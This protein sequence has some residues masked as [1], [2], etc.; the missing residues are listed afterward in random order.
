MRT[1]SGRHTRN[2][3]VVIGLGCGKDY[4][5]VLCLHISLFSFSWVFGS[6]TLLVRGMAITVVVVLV[7]YI[8]L[9]LLY[10]GLYE[11]V[12]KRVIEH[13]VSFCA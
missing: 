12:S 5:P 2:G 1:V 3:S 11:R 7:L 8:H 13:I 10:V 4:L 6:F 9:E